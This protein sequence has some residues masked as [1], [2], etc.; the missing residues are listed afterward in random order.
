[1]GIVN[2]NRVI[3]ARL[4]G[5]HSAFDTAA[6]TECFNDIFK[7]HPRLKTGNSRRHGIIDRKFP[8]N[9]GIDSADDTF[10]D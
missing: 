3:F 5:L 8:R 2:N 10:A 4:N 7:F 9:V 6:F 1:M